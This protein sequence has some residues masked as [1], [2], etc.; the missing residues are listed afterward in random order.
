MQKDLHKPPRK[1][2]GIFDRHT[3]RY[4]ED[5]CKAF[6]RKRSVQIEKKIAQFRLKNSTKKRIVQRMLKFHFILHVALFLRFN[7]N[8]VYQFR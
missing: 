3:R 1:G 4:V 5:F 2:T 8:G 7:G 6:M